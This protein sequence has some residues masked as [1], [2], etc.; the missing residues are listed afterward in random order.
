MNCLDKALARVDK[1]VTDFISS[2]HF[3]GR[4]SELRPAHLRLSRTWSVISML[5]LNVPGGGIRRL[6]G[7]VAG[8]G[9]IDFE[10]SCC[11]LRHPPGLRSLP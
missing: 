11:S 1:E 3:K 5:M 8:G 10:E 6:S 9:G 7:A 2:C 4:G